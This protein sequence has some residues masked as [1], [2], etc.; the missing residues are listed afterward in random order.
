MDFGRIENLEKVDFTLPADHASLEK[1]LGGVP[2]SS[3]KVQVGGVLWAN[4]GFAGTLYPPKTKAA[5]YL[6]EYT[7]QLN[8][9][10]LNATHYRIPEP[11][12]LRRWKDMAAEGFKFCPKVHNSISHAADLLQMLPYHQECDEK[13]QALQEKL[14]T[15]F[16][17]LPQTFSPLRL[18]ELLLF[19]EE[20]TVPQMAVELRHPGWY[21]DAAAL[22]RLCNQLYKKGLG[23]VLTDTPGRRDVLHMRLTNK[24]ALVRFNAHRYFKGDAARI[25]AWVE[26]AAYW[27]RMGLEN[28]YFFI[29]TPQQ[30]AMPEL[31]VYFIQQLEQHSGIR[32]KAPVCYE[33][34]V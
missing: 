27:L 28:F 31:V 19:L 4:P 10:E 16:M 12:I 6:R 32:L 8:T 1:I 23:L 5:D 34:L 17:Q 21:T 18:N 15:V 25:D 24:T 22:N 9:I 14:G 20:S 26:R 13:F 7:R 29:H 2:C 30:I 33:G 11:D 3:P